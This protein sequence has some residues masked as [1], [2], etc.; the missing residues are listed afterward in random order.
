MDLTAYDAML[1]DYYTPDKIIEQSFADNV[2]MALVPKKEAGGR[3]YVQPIEYGNPGGASA[4]FQNSMT[5][6]TVSKYKDFLLTRSKQYQRILVDHETLLSTDSPEEAFQPAFDEFDRGLRSLGEKLAHRLFRTSGG[7][8]GQCNNT[9]M[10][11][12]STITLLDAADAFNFQ[13]GQ[14][15]QLSAT[16]GTGTL[17]AAGAYVTV[18]GIDREQGLITTDAATDL[19]T[20]ISGAGIADYIF[21]IGDYNACMSGLA[22]W[23]P[24]DRSLS[25]SHPL[26]TSFYGVTRSDDSDRLGG[27]YLDG[28]KL[29]GTDEVLIK[30]VAKVQKH[31]G[32]PT[33]IFMNPEA[34]SDLQLLASSKV[35]SMQTFTQ[36]LKVDDIVLNIGFSGMR[37]I[38]GGTPVEI[39]GDRNCPSNRVYI[40]SMPTWKLWHTG[41]MPGFLGERFTGKILKLAETEDSLEGRVGMYGCLGCS[42]PAHNLVAK[43]PTN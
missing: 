18:T 42:A 25:V 38:I 10:S 15:V 6:A 35:F 28:T 1:K 37:V 9:S 3:R 8:I 34:F 22:D 16:D 4:N 24:T 41:D 33:H 11:G 13:L 23:L 31:G 19:A 27:L 12:T 40:L 21:P 20:S 17:R 26:T 29:G 5:N 30:G 36:M 43:I 7:N 32:K 14:L 2:F 39:F